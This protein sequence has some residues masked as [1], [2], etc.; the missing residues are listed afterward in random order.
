MPEPTGPRLYRGED[1]EASEPEGHAA[2]PDEAV[3]P[4]VPLRPDLR[5][6]VAKALADNLEFAEEL[7]STG[8][9]HKQILATALRRQAATAFEELSPGGRSPEAR[10]AASNDRDRGSANQAESLK[11]E[12][13]FLAELNSAVAGIAAGHGVPWTPLQSGDVAEASE[14]PHLRRLSFLTEAL[15]Q[16]NE[17]IERKKREREP[18]E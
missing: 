2:P 5:R 10:Q 17:G 14:G 12:E 9:P 13:T 7:E 15:H 6:G 18:A 11:A 3:L 1:R 8:D 16:L 4:R